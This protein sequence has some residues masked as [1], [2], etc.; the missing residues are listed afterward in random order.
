M[1]LTVASSYVTATFRKQIPALFNARPGNNNPIDRL[2]GHPECGCRRFR[3]PG[4]DGV[5]TRCV[6]LFA[7]T[8]KC[9][10]A[11]ASVSKVTA[12]DQAKRTMRLLTSTC[13]IQVN[14][15]SGNSPERL[16]GTKKAAGE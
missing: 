14:T 8:P 1:E 15:K 12:S 2:S 6:V 13:R 3:W 7:V 16:V 5:G 9:R 4:H 10:A 11:G